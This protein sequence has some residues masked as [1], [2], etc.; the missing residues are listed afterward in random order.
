MVDLMENAKNR[1]LIRDIEA[2]N[3][4]KLALIDIDNYYNLLLNKLYFVLQDFIR[5]TPELTGEEENE[6]YMKRMLILNSGYIKM[7]WLI[8]TLFSF[9]RHPYIIDKE[10]INLKSFIQSSMDPLTG[11]W[12]HPSD[13][14][15][16]EK[17]EY[18]FMSYIKNELE[19]LL[20][21]NPYIKIIGLK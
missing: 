14:L 2:V 19:T 7:D 10:F 17:S 11:K 8:A 6:I 18:A 15:I 4:R 21:K 13:I 5:Q 3:R 20:M 1:E 16:F 9:D 12:V